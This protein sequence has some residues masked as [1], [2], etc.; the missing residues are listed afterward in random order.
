M[1]GVAELIPRRVAIVKGKERQGME[2]GWDGGFRV[3]G[4]PGA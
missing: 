3:I 2:E 1:A 4:E